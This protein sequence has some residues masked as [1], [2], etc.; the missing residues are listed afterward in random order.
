MYS[1]IPEHIIE[2]IRSRAD[3]VDVVSE[4]V[5]LKKRGKNFFGV[6]PFHQE[7]TPSFSVSPERQIYRCFSCGAGGN[8]F[9]FLM[10]LEQ[11]SFVEALR[12]LADKTGIQLPNTQN[13]QEDPNDEVYQINQFVL[14][15][16]HQ[17][18][19]QTNTAKHAREY[20]TQRQVDNNLITTFK[21][22]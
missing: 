1:R 19:L 3:I 21:L 18:L 15:Y 13:E 12:S 17:V 14:D 5:A 10:E 8:V 20:L 4:H 16:Y 7:K 9:K 2:E 22:G 6:C 11:V